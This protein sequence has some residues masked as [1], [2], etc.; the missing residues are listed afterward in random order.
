MFYL[1]SYL[2]AHR[3]EYYVR[4]QNISREGDWNGWIVF[5]LQA[6]TEQAKNNNAKVKRIMTLYDTMKVQIHDITRSQFTVHLLDAIFD[7]P[8]FETTDL[9][10]RTGI[11]KPTAMSLLR[12]LKSAN[13]LQELRPGSGRRA[14]VLCFSELLNIAEGRK[15]V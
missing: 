1:S 6:I 8:I 13:I 10:A 9:V 7:K 15:I 14:A 12:Q 3:E 4:L 5:F 11:H 2:E